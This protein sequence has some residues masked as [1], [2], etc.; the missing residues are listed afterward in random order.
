LRSLAGGV[1]EAADHGWVAAVGDLDDA[2]GILAGVGALGAGWE[3]LDQDKIALH[4]GVELGGWDENVV[5]FLAACADIACRPNEAESVTVKVEPARNET[6]ACRSGLGQAPLIA[7]G[8]DEGATRGEAG[9]LLQ[10][11]ATLPTA[12]EAQFAD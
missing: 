2:P 8:F 5:N 10:E 1:S 3:E 7:V 9:E 6:G 11:Q 4:G 12:T